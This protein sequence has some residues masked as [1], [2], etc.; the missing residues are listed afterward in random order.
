MTAVVVIA[1]GIAAAWLTFFPMFDA[2]KRE[3]D[4]WPWIFAGFVT[5]PVS[6]IVYLAKLR[7]ER[8]VAERNGQAT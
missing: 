7:A 4:P 5:G 6:G 3:R 1:L 2:T 8:M